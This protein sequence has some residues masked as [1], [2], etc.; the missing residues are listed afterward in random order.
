MGP[1][2]A[3]Q[4][5]LAQLTNLQVPGMAG[6]YRLMDEIDG[7]V[8]YFGQSSKFNHRMSEHATKNW[9]TGGGQVG[10]VSSGDGGVHCTGATW[11]HELMDELNRTE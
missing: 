2:W 5:K 1:Q 11:T 4:Q 7:S 10:A 3:F 6:V 8:I 9:G